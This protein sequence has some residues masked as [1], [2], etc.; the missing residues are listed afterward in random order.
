VS[1]D[2]AQ[3]LLKLADTLDDHDDVAN[4]YADFDVSDEDIAKA[5]G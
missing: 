5:Q 3:K 2:D 4:V 1:G